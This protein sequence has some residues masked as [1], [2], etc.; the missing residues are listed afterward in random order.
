L[1]DVEELSER[2]LSRIRK[3]YCKLAKEGR[4]TLDDTGT[5]DLDENI[6]GKKG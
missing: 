6:F 2:D 3:G 5:P 1:L 4:A